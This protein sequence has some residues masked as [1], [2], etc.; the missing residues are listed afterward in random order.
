M[1][2][3]PKIKLTISLPSGCEA[4]LVIGSPAVKRSQ[5]LCPI[6][7]GKQFHVEKARRFAI[8]LLNFEVLE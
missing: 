7:T 1:Y 8:E 6:S 4:G 5:G 3:P 2:T